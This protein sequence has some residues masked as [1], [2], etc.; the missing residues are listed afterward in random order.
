MEDENAS[1]CTLFRVETINDSFK[2]THVHTGFDVCILGSCEDSFLGLRRVCGNNS[3]EIEL[4]VI[5]YRS[6]VKRPRYV[7]F[8]GENDKFLANVFPHGFIADDISD[9]RIV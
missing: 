4:D 8:K 3:S 2:F 1:S 9:R 6:L 7:A 5:D